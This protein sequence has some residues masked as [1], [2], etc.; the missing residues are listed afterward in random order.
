MIYV[1]CQETLLSMYDKK[2]MQCR[3]VGSCVFWKVNR[4]NLGKLFFSTCFEKL[5]KKSNCV[6]DCASWRTSPGKE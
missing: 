3:D 2:G 5:K 1:V 4:R 6:V